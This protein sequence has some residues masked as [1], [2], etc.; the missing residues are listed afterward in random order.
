MGLGAWDEDLRATAL[1][2]PMSAAC[3]VAAVYCLLNYAGLCVLRGSQFV[4]DHMK[5]GTSAKE[6]HMAAKRGETLQPPTPAEAAAAHQLACTAIAYYSIC[7]LQK[8]IEVAVLAPGYWFPPLDDTQEG[9]GAVLGRDTPFGS[10]STVRLVLVLIIGYEIYN[11]IYE[12]VRAGGINEHFA[13]HVLACLTGVAALEAF[14]QYYASFFFGICSCTSVFLVPMDLMDTMP[15]LKNT[16][17]LTSVVAQGLFAASFLGTR[18]F[19]WLAVSAQW[20]EDTIFVCWDQQAGHPCKWPMWMMGTANIG[21]TLLQV[22]W[23][24]KVTKGVLRVLQSGKA[25]DGSAADDHAATTE[26]SKE[27]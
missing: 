3:A 1:E 10:S 4:E 13:H 7:M 5:D 24:Y 21:L 18:T 12:V 17:P 23:S 26:P 8:S 25:T 14:G 16:Y 11:C 9:T 6:I 27:D 20:W 22:L 15:K 2:H 19:W